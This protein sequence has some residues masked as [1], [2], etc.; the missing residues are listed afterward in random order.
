MDVSINNRSEA[1]ALEAHFISLYNT[2]GWYNKS[3]SN[4]GQSSFLPKFNEGDWKNFYYNLTEQDLENIRNKRGNIVMEKNDDIDNLNQSV[5]RLSKSIESSIYTQNELREILNE[6]IRSSGKIVTNLIHE[7]NNLREI[8]NESIQ[9]SN[10]LIAN[11]ARE[12]D[13]L[14]NTLKKF[15]SDRING[16]DFSYISNIVS[17]NLEKNKYKWWAAFVLLGLIFISILAKHN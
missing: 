1:E 17:R 10:K 13:E 15:I 2:G 16:I 3:K 4:W 11:S 12:R 5:R 7:Q 8:L 9:N 14:K 6:S